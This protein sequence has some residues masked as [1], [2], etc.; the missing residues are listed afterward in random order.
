MSPDGGLTLTIRGT[1][2]PARSFSGSAA[3]LDKL[4]IAAAQYAFAQAQPV[5]WATY[6]SV[7]GHYQEVISFVRTRVAGAA[8]ADRPYLLNLWGLALQSTGGSQEEAIKIFQAAL[9][10]KPDLWT[11]AHINLQGALAAL[12][13]EEDAWRAGEGMR[14]AA[15]GRPG[16]APEEAY[17]EWD[18]LTWNLQ[19][20]LRA[21][22][23][24]SDQLRG[25]SSTVN[26]PGPATADLY[27]RLHDT[28][29]AELAADSTV[30]NDDDPTIAAGLHFARGELALEAH[31]APAALR[32][33]EAFQLAYND[34]AV[35]YAYAGYNCWVALA[36]ELAGH[37]KQADAVLDSA[38]TYVDCGRFRG[39]ILDGRGD[40][41]GAQKAYG[42]AIALAPDLPAA[43]FSWG[44]ALAR[45]H[46]NAAAK[47]QFQKA[48]ERGPHWADPLKAWGDVLASEGRRTEALAKYTEALNYAPQWPALREASAKL[49]ASG[50]APQT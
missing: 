41:P 5:L 21:V 23:G 48:N 10:L 12:A 26:P 39:D 6:L 40:W 50:H 7:P 22:S 47:A 43:Y 4:E 14:A 35:K 16:R 29:A 32:E 11:T 2:I 8:P 3:D 9:A 18:A 17:L 36:E 37:S 33:M 44:A 25:Y 15:G 28:S 1:A 27:A 20:S 46:Q 30:V 34:P 49:Q 13:R 19:A 42:A 45:H 24:N 31:D 38:G